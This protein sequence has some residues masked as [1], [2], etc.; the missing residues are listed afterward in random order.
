MINDIKNILFIAIVFIGCAIQVKGQ[1][2]VAKKAS[3]DKKASTTQEVSSIKKSVTTAQSSTAIKK[4]TT[5]KKSTINKTGSHL[6]FMGIPIDGSLEDIAP[7]L[8][9]K[10]FRQERLM[11]NSFSGIFYETL[12]SINVSTDNTTEKVN[13]VKVRYY[14]GVNGLSEDQMVSL[15]NRIVRGLK[16]KYT[17]AKFSKLDGKT[18]LSMP[19][20]YIYC[21]I[22]NMNLS[23]NFG[24]GTYIELMYVDKKNTS[25]YS[26]PRLNKADD[27]L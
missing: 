15:Y 5:T 21:E 18:L 9:E 24:G 8:I 2:V 19:L 26:L 11:P 14:T 12:A 1:D 20:G 16:K 27:D 10:N 22:Y 7:K 3:V 17:Y 6:L 4:S 25:G 23:R 13:S